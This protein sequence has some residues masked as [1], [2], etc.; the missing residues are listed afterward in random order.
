MTVKFVTFAGGNSLCFSDARPCPDIRTSP[1]S[2]PAMNKLST[3]LLICFALF[4][5]AKAKPYNVDN[6]PLSRNTATPAY[7]CNPDGILTPGT[8]DSLNLVLYDLEKAKGVKTLVIVVNEIEGG[9]A[10]SLAVGVGNKYGV[11]SRQN[12]GL[13]IVLSVLDRSY[14][15][16]TGEGLESHLPDAICKRVENR[17]MVPLLKQGEWNEAMLRT[18]TTLAGILEGDEEL[19]AEYGDDPDEAI[20]YIIGIIFIVG[21]LLFFIALASSIYIK[22]HRCPHCHKIKLQKTG[23]RHFKQGKERITETSY[24]CKACGKSTVRQ[25]REDNS[26]HFGNGLGGGIFLGGGLG[27]GRSSGGGFGGGFGS[28]GGGSFGGGGAGSKF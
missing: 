18:A 20:L 4:L 5:T 14:F 16:A 24:L 1:N 13:V 27:G 7:V 12:T 9:D 25:H 26:D 22:E 19:K 3:I 17:V 21:I 28:F 15:I 2:T 11:G 10:Y 8:V 23:E 6:L